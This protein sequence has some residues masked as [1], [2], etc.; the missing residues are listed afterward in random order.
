VGVAALAMACAVLGHFGAT[1]FHVAPQNVV[2]DQYGTAIR[3]YL[4]PEFRQGWSLFAPDLPRSE[5]RRDDRCSP[6][7]QSVPADPR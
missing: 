7:F 4:Y 2:R 3:G 5:L 1:F 6:S